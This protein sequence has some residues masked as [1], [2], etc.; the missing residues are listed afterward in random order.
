MINH[1]KS[2]KSSSAWI[3]IIIVVFLSLLFL[4]L[5][6]IAVFIVL[7][8]FK[9]IPWRDNFNTVFVSIIIPDVTVII[10]LAQLL[11]NI[12]SE[13]KETHNNSEDENAK[14][15]SFCDTS[16]LFESKRFIKKTRLRACE[17]YFYNCK[18]SW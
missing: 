17:R 14:K 7:G 8:T 18:F 6:I 13:K 1:Q 15:N 5:I 12:S 11:H 9:V 10:A 4:L 16:I 2:R 3:R